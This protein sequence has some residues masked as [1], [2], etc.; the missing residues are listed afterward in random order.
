MA[1]VF[2]RRNLPEL[3]EQWGRRME[4]AVTANTTS[5]DILRQSLQGQNRNT[6]SSLATLASQIQAIQVT[7][8]GLADVVSD[9]SD[10]VVLLQN[11]STSYYADA[12]ATTW[13]IAT[14]DWASGSLPSV[15]ATS[16][17]GRFR[18]TVSAGVA[19]GD[20]I[21]TFSATGFARTRALGSTSAAVRARLG[22]AGGVSFVGSASKSWVIELP[23]NTTR[24]F[25]AEANAVFG[26][27]ATLYGLDILVEP[28]L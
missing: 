26:A 12:G 19:G 9:L 5:I 11:A 8:Q 16:L 27:P 25:T 21:A 13:S 24:T 14:G 4:D 18:I 15:T 6:A 23:A 22:V 1:E 17:S 3:A 28:L 2:P 7:Q 10:T 20:L